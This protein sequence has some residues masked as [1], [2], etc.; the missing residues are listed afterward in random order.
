MKKKKGY[1]L[2]ETV[3]A[4]AI[5]LLISFSFFSLSLFIN[6]NYQKSVTITLAINQIENIL[7]IFKSSSFIES[8]VF[9]T[10][11]FE[12]NIYFALNINTIDKKTISL[13]KTEY[14]IIFNNNLEPYTNGE[15]EIIFE[16]TKVETQVSCWVKVL[17]TDKQIYEMPN[18]FYKAV[19]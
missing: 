4:I 14:T 11:E 1:M 13:D 7:T 16:I 17:K 2:T 10:T 12:E 3:I 5:I 9:D 18:V 15:V 8:E 6:N 19:A